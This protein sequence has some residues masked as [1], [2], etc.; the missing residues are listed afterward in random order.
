MYLRVTRSRFDLTKYGEAVRLGEEFAITLRR[1]PGFRSY[2]SGMDRTM[3]TSIG[4]SVWDTEEQ[5]RFSRDVLGDIIPRMLAQ[6]L[7]I[8]P[9]EFYEVAAEASR[10]DLDRG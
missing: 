9:P 3:G 4:V 8:D 1:L 5:A 6:G 10:E 7:Q 2:H